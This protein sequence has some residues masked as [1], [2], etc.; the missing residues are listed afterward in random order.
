MRPAGRAPW[1]SRF[2]RSRLWRSCCPASLDSRS[3]QQWNFFG[4][5]AQILVGTNRYF[6]ISNCFKLSHGNQ[7]RIFMYPSCWHWEGS[8]SRGED[9]EMNWRNTT[10]SR[11]S[12]CC[13]RVRSEET[14]AWR[15]CLGGRTMVSVV[16][17]SC[18][19]KKGDE[20]YW[21][22][23]RQ[24]MKFCSCWYFDTAQRW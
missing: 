7:A 19:I 4:T 1:A 5:Q 8:W 6:G 14:P 2:L 23:D 22:V 16:P 3:N 15:R 18:L 11:Q 21:F 17:A 12:V 13:S 20:S 24:D 10:W 9:P